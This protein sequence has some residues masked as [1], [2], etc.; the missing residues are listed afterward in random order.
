MYYKS[1][2]KI[3]SKIIFNNMPRGTKN[4]LII[5]NNNSDIIEI[6]KLREIAFDELISVDEMEIINFL[7]YL[8]D[9]KYEVII[10]NL[11]MCNFYKIR[12]IIE[13]LIT[14]SFYSIVRFRNNNHDNKITKKKKIN[15][16]IK[17]DRINIIKKFYGRKNFVFVNP[18][19]KYFSYYT[20]YFLTK[21][22]LG[23][24][25]ELSMNDKIKKYFL[26]GREALNN[27]TC[28]KYGK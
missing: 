1:R 9:K 25:F 11:E 3:N 20:V 4:A 2:P 6:L 14:K 17:V 23:L 10:L 15:N 16:I 21:N 28:K 5:G 13:M 22:K 12:K 27:I 26:R 7:S 18:L 24:N 8:E 19:F